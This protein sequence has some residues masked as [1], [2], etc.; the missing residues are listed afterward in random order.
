MAAETTL[1]LWMD[2][3][4]HLEPVIADHERLFD[5]WAAG[6][7]DGL[8]IGPMAFEEN[9]ATFDPDARIYRRLG[10]EPPEPPSQSLPEKRA[11]LDRALQAAK[12]RGWK[13]WIF[14]PGSGAPPVPGAHGSIIVDDRARAAYCARIVDTMSHYPMVDGAVLD[15]PEWGY[16]I[17]P[18]HMVG[19]A[20]PRSYLFSDLPELAA[21]A[22]ATLGYDYPALVQVK[23]RLYARLHSLSDR[24]VRLHGGRDGGLLGAFGL[25]GGD[26]DLARWIAFRMDALTHCYA[27]VRETVEANSARKFLLAAGPRSAAFAPLCGYDLG[28]L[29]AILDVLLPKHYVWHRGFDGMYGTVARYVA[30]LTRWNPGLSEV[31]ALDVVGALFGLDLPGVTSLADFDEGF[32]QEFFDRV[33]TRESA[34]VLAATDDPDRVVPWVDAG[35]RPHEGDPVSA[36]DLGRLLDATARAGLRRFIYHHHGNLTPGEWAVISR[37]CGTPWQT[38]AQPPLHPNLARNSQAMTGYYPPDLPAL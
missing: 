21:P 2:V 9:V 22:C 30:T 8:V 13:V 17:S 10:L 37:R 19:P 12:D 38:M 33:V 27:A 4:R 3:M 14:Q 29:A 28:R 24:E 34:R 20:G 26:P 36:G 7:V 11:L 6:G 23:D 18:E 5:A 15:G 25:L 35:R 32:P 16:E 1:N 31:A